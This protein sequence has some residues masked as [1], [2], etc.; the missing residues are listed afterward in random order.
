MALVRTLSNKAWPLLV[1][2]YVVLA[3][4]QQACGEPVN[5]LVI[6]HENLAS[7]ALSDLLSLQQTRGFNVLAFPISDGVSRDAVKS[8]IESVYQDGLLRY[9]LLVGAARRDA[10]TL[11]EKSA[12]ASLQN[13]VPTFFDYDQH[14][15]RTAFDYRYS[16]LDEK[17]IKSPYLVAWP[18]VLIGRIPAVDT[19]DLQIYVSK[20]TY[21]LNDLT[22]QDWKNDILVI[23]GDRDRGGLEAGVP[24][25]QSIQD[26]LD[27]VYGS[28]P[29][30]FDKAFLSHSDY[31]TWAERQSAV[32]SKLNSGSILVYTM[33]TGSNALNMSDMLLR[34]GGD[35]FDASEDLAATDRYSIF[36]AASCN[37]GQSD[38]VSE[39]PTRLF[40]E[41]LL[42]SANRGAIAY[43]GPCGFSSQTENFHFLQQFTK[44]FYAYSHLSIGEYFVA[45]QRSPGSSIISDQTT[46]M[47][48]TL[49]GDPSIHINT[50]DLPDD[51]QVLFDFEY[52]QPLPYEG[53]TLVASSQTD[54]SV[55]YITT[56]WGYEGA[57]RVFE[58]AGTDQDS[59]SGSAY[60]SWV[61]YTEMNLDITASTR[62]LQYEIQSIE[63]PEGIGRF[64][65]NCVLDD[66]TYLSEISVPGII[67]DQF[68]NRIGAANRQDA[69]GSTNW[70]VFDLEQLIG[71]TV[72]SLIVEYTAADPVSSGQ[73]HFVID[74]IEFSEEWG[75]EPIVGEINAPSSIPKNSQRIVSISA[76]D[77]DESLGDT[78]TFQWS[79]T[80]GSFSGSGP[81]VTY[82]SPSQTGAA[83]LTCVVSDLGGHSVE[84]N[85]VVNIYTP[86]SGGCP[87][88]YVLGD[89]GFEKDNVILTE[90]EDFSR[91]SEFV[92]DYCPLTVAPDLSDGIV[93]MRL[94]EEEREISYIDQISLL[95]VPYDLQKGEELAILKGSLIAT[96][97]QIAPVYAWSPLGDELTSAVTQ[98]D[99]RRFVFHGPG[100]LLLAYPGSELGSHVSGSASHSLQ[101]NDEG[102]VISIQ[103]QSKPPEDP[104]KLAAS[105]SGSTSMLSNHV[106]VAFLDQRN[107]THIELNKIYPRRRPTLPD[108]TAL[109][110]YI[111]DISL[112]IVSVSWERYFS[113]DYLP[114]T[115]Y[116]SL[117]EPEICRL[118]S[119]VDNQNRVVLTALEV[120]DRQ[121]VTVRPGGSV[122][123]MFRVPKT[124]SDKTQFILVTKGHYVR[125]LDVPDDKPRV[126]G[127]DQNYP[128]PF[129]IGTRIAYSLTEPSEVELTIYN[130][131]GQKV[132]TLVNE[133]Q[134]P[135]DYSVAWHGTDSKG[136]PVSSGI[137]LYRIRAGSLAETRKMLLLK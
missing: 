112:P 114:L 108:A 39:G 40:P 79:A 101:T 102:I 50:I 119:A 65:V 116:R 122:D 51:A 126:L 121:S 120:S 92:V 110:D 74:Y 7:D 32:V 56:S 104:F 18:N 42:F 111:R 36:L 117:P 135:G 96:G 66:G 123:L 130:I 11:T 129:N 124:T 82:H 10:D 6:H 59:A 37:L 25:V 137:Y 64:G 49:Y 136:N 98:K 14:G 27:Q 93:Y 24:S 115:T 31:S 83:I 54:V 67:T 70:Y 8:I 91:S 13:L 17:G 132:I 15:H 75:S 73:F 78:L 95:A 103:Q 81:Q 77:N 125:G 80:A 22:T 85:K 62:F 35:G 89:R 109:T 38:F 134:P 107:G 100:E 118:I 28:I 9:V 97:R 23:C 19:L 53:Q 84:R 69:T 21:Y 5:Y 60:T 34:G 71:E 88:F 52:G 127:I 55:S 29:I 58:V 105:A 128:N 57:N 131:L 46:L 2:A 113:A 12:N 86:S 106:T 76:E 133:N 87:D 68:G 30:V 16:I 43:V 33:A 94:V 90:S 99:D 41:N 4:G 61:L 3:C 1:A 45:A 44:T 26:E 20:L 48:Y 47:M 63:H 72:D